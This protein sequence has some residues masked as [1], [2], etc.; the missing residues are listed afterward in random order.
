[1]NYKSTLIASYL[2]MA[3]NSLICELIVSLWSDQTSPSV[4]L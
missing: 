2:K 3:Y 1:M 4:S